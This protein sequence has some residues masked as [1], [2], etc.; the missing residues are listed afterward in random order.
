MPTYSNPWPYVDNLP[1]LSED[2]KLTKDELGEL[3]CRLD[4]GIKCHAQVITES[5]KNEELYRIYGEQIGKEPSF[6]RQWVRLYAIT[7]KN[8]IKTIASDYLESKGLELSTW[9]M[10]VK[11]GQKGDVLT[12]FILSLITGVHCCV[13]LKRHNYW[14]TLKET[15]IMHIEYMQRCN[16]H[17]A[18]VQRGIFVE[19]TLRTTLVSYKLF[20]VDNPVELEEKTL[21]VIGTLTSEEDTTLDLL[22]RECSQ[23]GIETEKTAGPNILFPSS[24]TDVSP[25]MD[26]QDRDDYNFEQKGETK[27]ITS[28]KYA[29]REM[30]YGQEDSDST[31]I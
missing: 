30:D 8:Q 16:I 13:H 5:I 28:T 27:P 25:V 23:S 20:G 11:E 14:N 31:I 4:Y 26:N 29:I 7:N 10:G 2:M 18:F 9:L 3:E 19:L 1:K 6:M 17:L 12:L 21:V 22:L 24:A 15:P